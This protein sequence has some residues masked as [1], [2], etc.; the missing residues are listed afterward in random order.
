MGEADRDGSGDIDLEGYLLWSYN[1][2]FNEQ[3]C[4]LSDTE[5]RL[6]TIA[7]KHDLTICEIDEIKD[8]YNRFDLDGSGVIDKYEF[9]Q[10]LAQLF[11]CKDQSNMCENRVDR[12]FHEVDKD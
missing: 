5:L 3:L 8:A 12:F 7:R 11:R 1:N 4:G 2:A 10:I 6:R 9:K